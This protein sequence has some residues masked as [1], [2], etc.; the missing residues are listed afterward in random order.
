[1][2]VYVKSY[3]RSGVLSSFRERLIAA[4]VKSGRKVFK[5]SQGHKLPGQKIYEITSSPSRI[6]HTSFCTLAQ[7][8]TELQETP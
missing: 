5:I 4:Y 7:S 1:M 6:Q 8:T 3:L 2:K